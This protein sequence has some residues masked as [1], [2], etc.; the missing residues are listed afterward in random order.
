MSEL[1]LCPKLLIREEHKAIAIGTGDIVLS[2]F[3]PCQKEKCMAYR[4]G[5]CDEYSGQGVTFNPQAESEE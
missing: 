2:Y 5:M 4:D 1:R 3:Q